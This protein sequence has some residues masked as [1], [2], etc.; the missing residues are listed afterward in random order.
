MALAAGRE[1]LVLPSLYR[2]TRLREAGD[3]FA[4]ACAAAPSG[5]PAR[6]FQVGRGDVAEFALTL[7]PDGP[8]AS[9]RRG[10]YAG[11]AALGDALAAAAPPERPLNWVWP[12]TILLDGACIGGA[13]LAW[14]A[15]CAEEAEPAWL[16]FGA[17]VR[18]DWGAGFEGGRAPGA[19]ALL[20]EGF[21]PDSGDRLIEGFA[22]HLLFYFDLWENSGFLDVAS[23][24]LDRLSG[25]L[26]GVRRGIDTN[27]DLLSDGGGLTARESLLAALASPDWPALAGLPMPGGAGA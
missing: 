26:P 13:H 8:L 11:M 17:T 6:L 4:A 25:G 16:V 3:A 14:P 19:T 9:A 18:I 23:A 27:G 7:A 2:L 21:A 15:D 22:R 5:E 10:F 1:R 20:A 24:Y 12:G